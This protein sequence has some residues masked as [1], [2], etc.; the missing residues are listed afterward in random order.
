[1]KYWTSYLAF[2]ILVTFRVDEFT[3]PILRRS[4]F[5]KSTDLNFPQNALL[6]RACGKASSRCPPLK[7]YCYLWGWLKRFR[8]PWSG[9]RIPQKHPSMLS[10]LTATV[11]SARIGR[12]VSAGC[13]S[14]TIWSA[15]LLRLSSHLETALVA[16]NPSRL[17]SSRLWAQQSL[18]MRRSRSATLGVI[19]DRGKRVGEGYL[20]LIKKR[21]AWRLDRAAKDL[22]STLR[23]VGFRFRLRTNCETKLLPCCSIHQRGPAVQPLDQVIKLSLIQY[24]NMFCNDLTMKVLIFQ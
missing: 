15:R 8:S 5:S 4:R 12:F 21:I 7:F 23:W 3:T 17:P 6:R 14:D 9:Q 24:V 18:R 11:F 20:S 13:F 1:M 16:S 10:C 22:V 19:T 2:G